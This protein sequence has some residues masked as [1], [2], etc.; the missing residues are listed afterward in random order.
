MH[1]FDTKIEGYEFTYLD[2]EAVDNSD[3]FFRR[4]FKN[5]IKCDCIKNSRKIFAQI[6]EAKGSFL[7]NIKSLS[8]SGAEIEFNDNDGLNYFEEINN[9][10]KGINV[11]TVIVIMVDEFPYTI[12]NILDNENGGVKSALSF[13][14]LNRS[15]RNDPEINGKVQFIN[16]GSIGLNTTVEK[17]DATALINDIESI[18]VNPLKPEEAKDLVQKILNTAGVVI[19]E[20]NK[21]YILERVEWLT[22]FYLKLIIKEAIDLLD[23]EEQMTSSEIDSAFDEIIDYRNNNY[24]EHYYSRLKAYFDDQQFKFI[25]EILNQIADNGSIDKNKLYEIATKHELE[26]DYRKLRSTIVY[27]GYIHTMD[28]G[29]TYIFNSPILRN[30]WKKH[31]CK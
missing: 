11:D 15:L 29:E 19:D 4:I 24:F 22:P 31:V 27:D 16:T 8:A 30:W 26:E 1:L 28:E 2:T 10:I 20:T 9:L 21:D 5:I 14:Q 6:K 17:I 7:K 25:I 18:T 23:D 3:D 13:L 12:G